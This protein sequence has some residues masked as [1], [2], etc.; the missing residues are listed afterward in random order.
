MIRI[1]CPRDADLSQVSRLRSHA[2]WYARQ[3][4]RDPQYGSKRFER[5]SRRNEVFRIPR[6]HSA[7]DL[8]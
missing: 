7:G 5:R 4:A 6:Q 2:S 3:V 1:T 8:A